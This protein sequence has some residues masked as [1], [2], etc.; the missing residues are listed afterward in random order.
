LAPPPSLYLFPFGFCS[1]SATNP[2]KVIADK[3]ISWELPRGIYIVGRILRTVGGILSLLTGRM[4]WSYFK[5]Y[6]RGER[7]N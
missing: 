6:H 4:E 7:G 1:W 5:W 3:R 2:L